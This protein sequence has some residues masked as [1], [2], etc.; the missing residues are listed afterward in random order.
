MRAADKTKLVAFYEAELATYGP[1]DPRSL[2]WLGAHTQ[3]VRF[4]MLHQVGPWQ[5][6]SV[7]DI[8]CGLGDFYGYLQ[9]QGCRLLPLH[10]Q[11]N[12]GAGGAQPD[13][14]VRYAGYDLSPRMAAA[15]SLKY[16]GGAFLVRDI[17]E[18]GLQAPCDYVVASGTFNIRVADHDAFFREMIAAMYAGCRRAV[19]FNF[20]GPA[21]GGSQAESIYYGADPG[22]VL[23]YCRT[24]CPRAVLREGYLHNDFTIYLYKAPDR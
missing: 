7:A 9:Q 14:C 2:H 23:R 12:P 24:L 1:Q 8:G 15:A 6:R 5:G 19:A 17:L 13:G 10:D 16:P 11:A 21:G 22:A 4:R 18:E 3:Q 20:L